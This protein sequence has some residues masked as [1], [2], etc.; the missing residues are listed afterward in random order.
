VAPV[1]ADA[2]ASRQPLVVE[3]ASG[4]RAAALP[5]AGELIDG[6]ELV[7]GGHPRVTGTPRLDGLRHGPSW[8]RM[9]HVM[10]GGLT[11]EPAV[12][13]ADRLVTLAPAGA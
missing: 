1:R 2:Q 13:L 6:H 12:A 7:V 4:V 10:F 5:T 3:S 11:H 8:G 9:G